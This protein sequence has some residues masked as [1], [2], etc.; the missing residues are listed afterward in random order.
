MDF[1]KMAKKSKPS[2]SLIP[3]GNNIDMSLV[4]E[5]SMIDDADCTGLQ[6]ALVSERFVRNWSE[7]QAPTPRCD[8]LEKEKRY[9]VD[10]KDSS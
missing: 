7:Y 8:C 5:A 3:R 1:R 9:D 2:Q 6:Q 10:R 4:E